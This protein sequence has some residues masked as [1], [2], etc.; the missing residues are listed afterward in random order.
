MSADRIIARWVGVALVLVTEITGTGDVTLLG[1]SPPPGAPAGAVVVRGDAPALG[2]TIAHE[3]G[4]YLGLFH[5]TE[6]ASPDIHD[7]LSDTPL[8][9][10]DNLMAVDGDGLVLTPDQR[11]VAREHPAVRGSCER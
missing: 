8:A 11:A 7:P 9:D 5:L 10:P 2:R 3:L 4:H 6:P 1:A